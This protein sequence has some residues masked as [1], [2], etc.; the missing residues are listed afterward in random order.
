MG[1]VDVHAAHALRTVLWQK[2]LDI[3]KELAEH[4]FET[5][6]DHVVH[7]TPSTNRHDMSGHLNGCAVSCDG[8]EPLLP[9]IQGCLEDIGECTSVFP[10]AIS[11]ADAKKLEKVILK[12]MVITD[13]A[14]TFRY[15]DAVRL[16][17]SAGASAE[18]Y[19]T[20]RQTFQTASSERFAVSLTSLYN[21][22]Q[23]RTDYFL[24]M[25][26]ASVVGASMLHEALV[27]D[28]TLPVRTAHSIV[29]D[30]LDITRIAQA[31]LCVTLLGAAKYTNKS[32]PE[33]RTY[34]V[35]ASAEGLF[36]T[37]DLPNLPSYIV[38]TPSLFI[39]LHGPETTLQSVF[40]GPHYV[41][42]RYCTS[43]TACTNGV[44]YW[45]PG[46]PVNVTMHARAPG[47]GNAKLG[48]GVPQRVDKKQHIVLPVESPTS[49]IFKEYRGLW[50]AMGGS[51]TNAIKTAYTRD[52]LKDSET[53]RRVSYL[54][55][56]AASPT[57]D[58][59][60]L[61][62]AAFDQTKFEPVEHVT[63]TALA[64]LAG[65]R[66][67]YAE[68]PL[69]VFLDV[70]RLAVSNST[71]PALAAAMSSERFL[72]VKQHMDAESVDWQS[73]V[74][75]V[76]DDDIAHPTPCTM[77]TFTDAHRVIPS[78]YFVAAPVAPVLE[79]V[80][81]N[82]THGVQPPLPNMKT[83]Q[84]L[85]EI[86]IAEGTAIL[87]WPTLLYA[88]SHELK[89]YWARKPRDGDSV[90]AAL[91]FIAGEGPVPARFH[92]DFFASADVVV[93]D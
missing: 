69:P 26:G 76:S 77:D 2:R 57:F 71:M 51:T 9:L 50:R 72:G 63:L 78:G 52:L 85:F 84:D 21:S 43:S 30:A 27:K 45:T 29:K 79:R 44:V 24:V 6:N 82:A 28:R 93:H 70:A 55:A 49:R 62:G 58:T 54:G 47:G 80:V 16:I 12:G 86:N 3:I 8:S 4:A 46:Q 83:S 19:A 33:M 1:H 36:G 7:C 74:T 60:G 40:S 61:L 10:L 88:D 65:A 67:P 92:M 89:R 18:P 91:R 73:G 81:A 66:F 37:P 5:T 38:S 31:A 22:E 25:R 68:T 34:T 13:K 23:R 56:P 48:E 41:L 53:V 11:D 32:F 17:S 14:T 20:L 35:P 90:E 42:Y 75:A 39:E 59:T 15:G 64:T 87:P